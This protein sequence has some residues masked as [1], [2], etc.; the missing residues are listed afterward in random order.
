MSFGVEKVFKSF[1][2]HF[3]YSHLV[4]LAANAKDGLEVDLLVSNSC[5]LPCDEESD[6][7]SIRHLR[8]QL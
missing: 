1:Y 8:K 2:L 7:D 3:K 6:L 4:G 5:L